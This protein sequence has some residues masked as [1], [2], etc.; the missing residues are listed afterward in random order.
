M[1][2]QIILISEQAKAYKRYVPKYV[3]IIILL[4]LAGI[5][6]LDIDCEQ[7]LYFPSFYCFPD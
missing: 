2:S 7:S 6:H 5:Y 4:I 3:R 1:A